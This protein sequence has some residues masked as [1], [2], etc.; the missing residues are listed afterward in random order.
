MCPG[1]FDNERPPRPATAGP[2]SGSDAVAGAGAPIV[3]P[4]CRPGTLTPTV[5]VTAE[6]R[7]PASG[8]I[9]SNYDRGSHQ[10]R[11]RPCASVGAWPADVE[12]EDE[13]EFP[14]GHSWATGHL[15]SW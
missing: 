1:P 2:A 8:H 9:T 14:P 10:L 13:P 3:D 5:T 6:L 15:D 4:C 12:L 11:A 7:Q